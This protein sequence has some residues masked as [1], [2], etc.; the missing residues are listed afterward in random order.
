MVH[1][2]LTE[3]NI[4]GFAKVRGEAFLVAFISQTKVD[5]MHLRR[6]ASLFDYPG[7]QTETGR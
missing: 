6:V 2:R 4:D 3:R 1:G 7:Q 5:A